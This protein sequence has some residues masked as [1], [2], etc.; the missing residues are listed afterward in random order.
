MNFFSYKKR[1][2]QKPMKTKMC[3]LEFHFNTSF[4]VWL[5]PFWSIKDKY[6]NI[7]EWDWIDKYVMR[8]TVFAVRNIFIHFKFCL[9]FWL[10]H[11]FEISEENKIL[12]ISSVWA[13]PRFIWIR[14]NFWLSKIYIAKYFFY[15]W[16]FFNQSVNWGED[17]WMWFEFM[18]F[19]HRWIFFYRLNKMFEGNQIYF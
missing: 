12:L 3:P 13:S 17:K 16:F 7:K 1:R 9:E 8:C 19:T 11:K 5:M 15:L 6:N 2:K 18:F 4:D 10:K 14:I